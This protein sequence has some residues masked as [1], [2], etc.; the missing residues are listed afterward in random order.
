MKKILG[1]IVLSLLSVSAFAN[2]HCPYTISYAASDSN[3]YLIN[4][5]PEAT[6][7]KSLATKGF[8]RV[9]GNTK[10][11]YTVVLG[12]DTDEDNGFASI[13]VT[14]VT[15]EL[16][17]TSEGNSLAYVSHTGSGGMF[18]FIDKADKAKRVLRSLVDQ[19]PDCSQL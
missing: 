5:S 17:R 7:V 6:M 15:M 13:P 10:A 9:Y 8:T 12:S 19:L 1:T 4:A 16:K 3:K 18:L 11:E 2:N 14:I